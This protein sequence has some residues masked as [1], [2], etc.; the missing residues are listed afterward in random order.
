MFA[1]V[2]CFQNPHTQACAATSRPSYSWYDLAVSLRSYGR[3]RAIVMR[4]ALGSVWN[5]E[6]SMHCWVE[7]QSAVV[8]VQFRWTIMYMSVAVDRS[9]VVSL[10]YLHMRSMTAALLRPSVNPTENN[11]DHYRLRV[12]WA[13]WSL[14]VSSTPNQTTWLKQRHM[15]YSFRSA[16]WCSNQLSWSNR[17]MASL[18][19][20]T[21]KHFK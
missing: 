11:A 9:V 19:R 8:C 13:L 3:L 16:E 2:G 14:V 18:S 21:L 6:S 10:S 12:H 17:T 4:V 15:G 20:P 5:C 7:F 1:S